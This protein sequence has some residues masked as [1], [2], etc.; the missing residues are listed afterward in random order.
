MKTKPPQETIFERDDRLKRQAKESLKA[1]KLKEAEKL[2]KGYKW[3]TLDE[4]TKK[5]VKL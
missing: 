4:K 3:I 1:V 5:L 2:K